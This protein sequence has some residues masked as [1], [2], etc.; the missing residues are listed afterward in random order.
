MILAQVNLFYAVDSSLR[1]AHLF[2]I[3]DLGYHRYHWSSQFSFVVSNIIAVNEIFVE[4][5]SVIV[6]YLKSCLTHL[7]NIGTC[8]ALE[9]IMTITVLIINIA[10]GIN[11][12][13]K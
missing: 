10:A 6:L 5:T 13:I 2:H 12:N 11:S 9:F 4:V 7:F 8:S 3:F 1:W